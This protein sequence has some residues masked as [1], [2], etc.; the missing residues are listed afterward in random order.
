MDSQT[1]FLL[2]E[3]Y[4]HLG[5]ARLSKNRS[6]SKVAPTLGLHMVESISETDQNNNVILYKI[7]HSI[8]IMSRFTF[9]ES[10]CLVKAIAAMRMLEKRNIESTLY[11]GTG[12]DESGKLI[13]HAWLRSGSFFITGYEGIDRFTVVGK[14]S[15]KFDLIGWKGKV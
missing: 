8:Q 2:L 11:L 14:F 9:W 4:Y 6:F 5:K 15:K 13:A 3:S 10:E 1:R 7:S 12:R